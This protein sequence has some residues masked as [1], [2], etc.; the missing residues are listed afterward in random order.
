MSKEPS[1][2][3]QQA[4]LATTSQTAPRATQDDLA[5]LEKGLLSDNQSLQMEAA[6]KLRHLLS[7]DR[8][9]LIH[10]VFRRNWV[11]YLL[12]WLRLRERPTLQV[13]ALWALTNVAAGTTE[14][15]HVL[16][17]NGAVPILVSL[18]DSPNDEVLEQSVWVLG[19][20][21]GEGPAAR[22]AV[23]KAAVL[24]PLMRCMNENSKLSLLRIATWACSNLCDGQPRPAFDI[25]AVLPTL[26]KVSP[27]QNPCAATDSRSLFEDAG[28]NR[29]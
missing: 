23:L 6:R 15:T 1:P 5:N 9:L 26:A 4:A 20:L 29:Y 28:K 7:S 24:T 22:D 16:I 13:E 2:P 21:A 25:N 17:K 18:L 11:P 3:G 10:E 12:R 19:N 14:H 27:D 8:D